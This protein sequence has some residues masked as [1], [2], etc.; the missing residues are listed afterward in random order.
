MKRMTATFSIWS[1][2]I[3]PEGMT[4]LAGVTPDSTALRGDARFPPRAVPKANGWHVSKITEN[5]SDVGALVRQ[6]L[7]DIFQ[8]KINYNGIISADPSASISVSIGIVGRT[9]REVTIFF[10]E[11][12]VSAIAAIPA[13]LDIEFF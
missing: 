9:P 10:D 6:L 4:K 7:D 13:S 5:S 2:Q 11:D 1:P 8:K 3:S 12:L